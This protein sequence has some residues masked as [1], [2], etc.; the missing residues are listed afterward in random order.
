MRPSQ[1][2]QIAVPCGP[3]RSHGA[4]LRLVAPDDLEACLDKQDAARLPDEF[5]TE[6]L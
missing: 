3:Q 5:D 2:H 1:A 6:A 4:A